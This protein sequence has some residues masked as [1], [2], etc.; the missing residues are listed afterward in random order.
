MA[1]RL[2]L[3]ALVIL[4]MAIVQR[5]THRLPGKTLRSSRI[6][7]QAAILTAA[8]ADREAHQED[9]SPSREEIGTVSTQQ[10]VKRV[11]AR[12]CELAKAAGRS[13][14]FRLLVAVKHPIRT[15]RTKPDWTM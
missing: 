8:L 15:L 13:P 7:G 2:R 12:C 9:C 1:S 11:Q 3:L 6:P 10:R 14:F 4:V 5:M